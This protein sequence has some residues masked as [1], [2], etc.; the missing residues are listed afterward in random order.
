MLVSY[1]FTTSSTKKKKKKTTDVL[2]ILIICQYCFTF[3]LK[4]K[5]V[6]SIFIPK[7]FSII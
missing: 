3:K 2:V 4:K 6:L 7:I 1:F 5:N